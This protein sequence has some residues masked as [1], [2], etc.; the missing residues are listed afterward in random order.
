MS[1]M[2]PIATSL[3][4]ALA[5]ADGCREVHA[6]LS[7]AAVAPTVS[8]VAPVAAEV[9]AS[10]TVTG[11]GF[12]DTG[13]A[14]RIGNGY[15]LD[16]PS[17]DGTTITFTLPQALD[18]C[19]PNASGPCPQAFARLMPGEYELSVI[20]SGGASNTVRFVVRED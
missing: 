20:T 3:V 18:A 15:V 8:A 1:W 13:N 5:P 12:T 7:P 4:L 10:V 6:P 2:L 11:T 9:G 19:P 14:I 16:L 17:S